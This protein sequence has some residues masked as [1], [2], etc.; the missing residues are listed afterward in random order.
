MGIP[1]VP[2]VKRA[3]PP[4]LKERGFK[5]INVYYRDYELVFHSLNDVLDW[6]ASAGHRQ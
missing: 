4:L 5:N 3:I 1:V 2:A 6:W